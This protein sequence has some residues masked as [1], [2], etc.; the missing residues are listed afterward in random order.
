MLT[1]NNF[2]CERCGECCKVYTVV[3]NDEDIHRIRKLGYSLDFFAQQ[4]LDPEN[5]KLQ[6]VLKREDGKCIFLLFKNN[7]IYCKIYENRPEICKIYP[8]FHEEIV[9]CKPKEL[10]KNQHFYKSF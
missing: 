7:E 1:K 5:R 8:F 10:L 9:S 4:D 2:T 6:Y 3:L